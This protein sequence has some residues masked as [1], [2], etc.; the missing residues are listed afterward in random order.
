MSKAKENKKPKRWVGTSLRRKE[1][2]R[3]IRG[4]GKFV[5]DNRLGEM[6]FLKMVSSPYGHAKI[7]KVDVSEAEKLPGVVCTLTGTEVASLMQPFMEIGPE[8]GAKIVDY[9][10]AVNRARYQGEPVAAVIAKSQAIAEDAAELVHV[11]Y[12]MLDAVVTGEDA[13]QDKVI[14]HESSGTNL[15]W[16]GL[17]EWGEVDKAFKEAAYVVNIDRL[18][19]HRFT[20]APLENNAI[21]AHWEPD[22]RLHFWCNNSFP[23]FA[24][25]FLAPALGLRLEQIHV[26]TEDIGGSFGVKITHY[27]QM[28]V[29]ALA[30][31]KAGGRPVKW[32]ET[33]TGN[34]TA[35]GHC[36][37]RTY[38]NTRVAL[39]KNGV[40]Q[41]IESRQIDDCGAYTRYE[42][43]GAVIWSQVVPG[44]YRVKNLRIDFAQVVSNKCP[45]APIRG[46]SRLQHLWFM[47]RVLD[48]C[49]YELGIAA[50]EMRLQNYIKPEEFPYTTPNGCV[51]DSGNYPKMLEIAKELVGWD[52]WVKKQQEAKKEGRM[53]GIGIGTTLDSGTNNFGQSR[54]INPY[55][56]FSGNSEAA[57]IK[58]DLDGNIVVSLGSTPQ[59]QG[60]ETT[61]AQVVADE[62]NIHPD[63]VSVRTGFDTEWNTY[64]GHSGTYASQF[65]V[66]GLSAVHGAAQKLKKEMKKLAAYALQAKEEDLEFGVGNMGPEL[67]V[68]GTDKSI[69]YWGLAN[70][71][72]VNNAGLPNEIAELTLNCRYIYRP[73]FQI[74]DL[75]RKYGNLTLTYAAQLHIAV[76]EIDPEMYTPKILD[77][78]AVDDCGTVVNPMIVE[79]QVRG[80][81]A[82]GIGAAL[83]E[84]CVYDSVGNMLTSTFSDYTPITAVNMPKVHY[85]HI[86][87]PSPFSFNG[88]KGMGEGGGAA[89]H[90]ISAALQNALFEYGITIDD[91]FTTGNT[92]YDAL[93]GKKVMQR[94]NNVKVERGVA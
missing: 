24:I 83:M 86:E 37:E 8:P 4:H 29:C 93:V 20:A 92:L 55:A 50:D 54:I 41:A 51:Y 49:S 59:G 9:P 43:L 62:L 17:Y 72:N 6:L 38:R 77:Y 19:F 58:V 63:M 94:A 78:A 23:T 81:T 10:M 2:D 11:E 57:N 45:C 16:R 89:L 74:P 64:T 66:T 91:S 87:S 18:H 53:I 61:T 39:D 44:V 70:L 35:S 71:V 42:P 22:G 65:A 56:P 68:K 21:L 85:G 88:A 52:R 60:H 31:R 34:L 26:K 76:V 40:I 48:I 12:E 32:T 69:N 1:D 79:G 84:A 7:L 5:D 46:Y 80:A 73:P 27:P 13:I 82:H 28:A 67:R 47:E 90:A 33:R 36:N 14:L 30:S 15:V 25:Q 75:K 3:L